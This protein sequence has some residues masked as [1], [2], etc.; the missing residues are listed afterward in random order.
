MRED[1]GHDV[2]VDARAGERNAERAAREV[3][4]AREVLRLVGSLERGQVERVEG[5]AGDDQAR[6]GRR[7]PPRPRE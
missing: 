3:E 6:E 4:S 7:E 5:E 2:G 1:R